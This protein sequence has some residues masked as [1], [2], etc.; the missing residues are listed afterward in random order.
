MPPSASSAR[1]ALDGPT[2]EEM[3]VPADAFPRMAAFIEQAIV[4]R[5]YDY[6]DEFAYG[7]ELVLDGLESKL[8]GADSR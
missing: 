4:G 6:G 7:L 2:P 1:P 5:S 8:A 3:A